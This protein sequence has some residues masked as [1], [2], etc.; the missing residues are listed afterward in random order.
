MVT[1]K[2][3]QEVARAAVGGCYEDVVQELKL[4]YDRPRLVYEHHIQRFDELSDIPDSF[5][6]LKHF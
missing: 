5:E 6:G 3:K 1:D 4:V 2:S